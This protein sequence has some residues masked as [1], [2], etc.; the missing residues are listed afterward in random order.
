M[1][2]TDMEGKLLPISRHF[3]KVMVPSFLTKLSL[4][5]AFCRK[6]SGEKSEE[7]VLTS[8]KGTW[9]VKTGKCS[10]GLICFNE[11][12][13]KFV[14]HHGLNLGDFVVFEHKGDLH[15]NVS[16]FDSSACEKEFP[17]SDQVFI[18]SISEREFPAKLGND[19]RKRAYGDQAFDPST[20]KKEISAKLDND[21]IKRAT[22]VQVPGKK[23]YPAKLGNDQRKSTRG[24][25][26]FDPS[27]CENEIHAKLGNDQRKRPHCDQMFDPSTC[28]REFIAKLGNDQRKR[29]PSDP[30]FDPSACEKEFPAKLGYDQRKR[31]PGDQINIHEHGKHIKRKSPLEEAATYIPGGP[32]FITTMSSGHGTSHSHY[33]KVY[34]PVK[35]L[36]ESDISENG[37]LTLRDPSGKP[38]PVKLHF[39]R[40][41]FSGKSLQVYMTKGWYEFYTS[42][43]LKDGDVCIF[44][45][46]RT[47]TRGRPVMMDVRI[48]PLQT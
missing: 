30:A 22:G 38:W 32:H 20:C 19:Q 1:S 25:Q 15:F 11:G 8:S 43:K 31:G 12:W 35:F 9:H 26:V 44:E 45:L 7:A 28:E 37:S 34:I 36:K 29:E 6:V 42:N 3:F 18:P 27:T 21:Q 17:A 46:N 5:P 2:S 14:G 23:E 33:P 48:F 40:S 4:P 10:K 47:V 16:V 39:S 41:G 24:D 13:D